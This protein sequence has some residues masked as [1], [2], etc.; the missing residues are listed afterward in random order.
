[1]CS[2]EGGRLQRPRQTTKNRAAARHVC[3]HTRHAA[4]AS[5]VLQLA[6]IQAHAATI[7]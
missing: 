7:S 3:Q 6:G 1:M 4:A 5:S 2:C